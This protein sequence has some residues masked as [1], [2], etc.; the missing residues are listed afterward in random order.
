MLLTDAFSSSGEKA[1]A[2]LE[3][4]ELI[5][6]QSQNGRPHSIKPGRPIYGPAFKQL[7]DDKVLSAKMDLQLLT[8]AIGSEN[9]SI[10]KY[11]QEL[12]L[13]GQL[14][15]QPGELRPRIQWLLN[16]IGSSQGKVENFE[17][18]VADMKKTLQT[19]F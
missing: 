6:I 4:A 15:G 11:E 19:E 17:K 5:S 12:Q 10:D 13:L 9:K 2:A 8:Q 7:V 14:P 3:S 16:K 18:E 1:L